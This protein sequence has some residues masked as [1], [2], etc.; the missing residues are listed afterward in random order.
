MLLALVF[1]LGLVG[2]AQEHDDPQVKADELFNEGNSLLRAGNLAEAVNKYSEALNIV[3]DHRYYYQKALALLRMQRFEDAVSSFNDALD[4]GSEMET[5]RQGLAGAYMGKGEEMFSAGNYS[6]AIEQYRQA[7]EV[8]PD[9]RFYNRLAI[10][11]RRNNQEQQAVENFKKAV[12]INPQYSV[13]YAGLGGAYLSLRQFSDA[14]EAYTT[15]LELE[16]TMEQAR[17]GIAAAYTAQGNEQL[18]R[19]RNNDAIAML[20]NAIEYHPQH[21]QAYLLLAVANN[22]IGNYEAAEQ[23]ARSAIEYKRSGQKGAEYFELGVALRRQ[24]NKN[25]AI[26][27]FQEAAKDSRYRRNAEYELEELR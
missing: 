4:H 9:P 6:G 7:I 24:G 1:S 12:E 16:P 8:N 10:A 18:E 21:S 14:I 11:Q 3:E 20:E 2:I 23:H 25:E 27:A 17:T 15:A 13:A 26:A 19:G 22:R 5:V